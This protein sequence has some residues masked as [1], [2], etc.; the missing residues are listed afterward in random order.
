MHKHT[1]NT[2]VQRKDDRQ[3]HAVGNSHK[4]IFT[5]CKGTYTW[6]SAFSW[7]ITSEALRYGMCSQ[8][9]SQFYPH[10]HKFNPQ[11][12]IPAF[13]FPATAGTYLSTLERWKAEL[14]WL[15]GYIVRQFTCLKAVTHPELKG[16]NCVDQDQCITATLNHHLDIRGVALL[17][18][19]QDI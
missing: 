8:G 9:I 15:A 6:Y 3:T 13:A 5:R 11:S 2:K 4:S 19:R 12:A 18:T 16:L 7:I 14:A 10:T 17:S 1:N